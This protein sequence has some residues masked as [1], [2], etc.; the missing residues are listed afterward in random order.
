MLYS[1]LALHLPDADQLT[2]Q[3]IGAVLELKPSAML[4]II[5][6]QWDADKGVAQQVSDLVYSL[7]H[8]RL[9]VR[10]H[11]DPSPPAYA[12]SIGGPEAWGEL[13]ASRM[14]QYYGSLGASG[15]DL[16][17]ILANEVD[18]DY[19]G[20]LPPV[21]AS[22]FYRRAL[23][24]YA[25]KRPQDTLHV[26]APTGAPSTHLDYLKRYHDDGWLQ[27]HPE[28]WIDGH[29]YG[30]DLEN[31]LD[32]IRMACPGRHY[33]IT[34]TNDL[35][36][37]SWPINLLAQGKADDICYFVL[38][39][40]RGGV[41]RVQPPSA[42]D[43]D[44]R[45]SLLRFPDRYQQFKA[46]IGAA[47]AE[48]PP[49]PMPDPPPPD[50]E[51]IMPET[52]P[53]IDVS[54]NNGHIDWDAVAAAGIKWGYAKVSE[55]VDFVDRFFP[56]NWAAMKEHGLVRGG[57]HFARPSE[58]GAVAEAMFFLDCLEAAGGLQAG[59]FIVLDFED[60]RAVG[61]LGPWALQWLSYVESRVGFKPMVYSGAWIINQHNLAAY[62]ALG[63]Y[64]LI[65]AA[66]QGSPPAAPA[67][68]SLMAAWQNDDHTGVPG[69]TGDHDVFF[70]S[71]E[72]LRKYGKPADAPAPHA[73]AY[74]VG[75]GV[76][77]AMAE[78]G[79]QPGSDEVYPNPFWSETMSTNGTYYRWLKAT[80]QTFRYPAA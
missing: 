26:P 66:Y 67:P 43:A 1:P 48:P 5:Y 77:A 31:V 7:H 63:E 34:E 54:N 29:G 17:A 13:C 10:F 47:I 71:V 57:Y 46:T 58:N 45:M 4:C 78:H 24:A 79:D 20:D 38:N 12:R 39:W 9:Y 35:D 30:P 37:F 8:D 28:Y 6:A 19:E 16:H 50:T 36:D 53:G 32:T 75:A 80:G 11:A 14:S 70:G 68:W 62:P 44:K 2:G 56:E 33:V 40:A 64:G 59:D 74:S 21:A 27:E 72:Q 22:D 65:L 25:R 76:L 73:L 3:E 52:S 23:D 55:G 61:D 60:E 69:V 42:D 15:V 49:P 18:A 41:G 51:P